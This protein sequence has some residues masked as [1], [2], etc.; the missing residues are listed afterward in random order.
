VLA[1]GRGNGEAWLTRKDG[2]RFFA[3]WITNSVH[4][5]DG[6][7]R[8]FINVLRDETVRQQGEDEELR[9]TQFAWELIEQQA[10]VTSSAL[11]RTQSEL[12][13]IGRRLLNVQEEERRRIARDLHDHLA[14]R[15]ALLEIGLDHLRKGLPGDLE[16]LQAE[17]AALQE[18][19][20]ALCEDVRDISHRLHP[21]IIE[22]LGLIEALK[23]LCDDYE[24]S[25][26]APVTFEAVQDGRTIPLEIAT[27]FY[28]ICEEGLRNVQKHAGDVPVCVQLQ[29]NGTEL[30]LRIQDTGPGFD[31]KGVNAAEH[32]GLLSM[33]E[34]ANLIGAVCKCI[35]EPGKGTA[36]EVRLIK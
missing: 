24:R 1:S 7:A 20:A 23:G 28:R 34:R 22:H 3:R 16:E 6:E 36:I 5:D 31:P 35:S 2:T 13:E 21:S 9:R 4:S 15:L 14:Q 17:I 10:R 33:R 29:A 11:G 27:A 18:H 25:R 8:G 26:V 32:L 12:T 19:T 30:R